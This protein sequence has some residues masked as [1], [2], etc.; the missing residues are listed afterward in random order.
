MRRRLVD[1][2]R[3]LSGHQS[4]ALQLNEANLAIQALQLAT[5]QQLGEIRAQLQQDI[6]RLERTLNLIGRQT[7]PV[8]D[9]YRVLFIVH[10][11]PNWSHLEPIYQL[12]RDAEDFD[13][14]VVSVDYNYVGGP[15]TDEAEVH[16]YLESRGIPHL[17]WGS[18]DNDNTRY[19][20]RY[21][22]P[23]LIFR[24][25]QWEG[26]VDPAL[27][28]SQSGFFRICNLPYAL[29]LVA[30]IEETIN[31]ELHHA[32]WRVFVPSELHVRHFRQHSRT[33]GRNVYAVGHPG[34]DSI[35][36]AKSSTGR[37][38]FPKNAG[39][40]RI[41]WAPRHCGKAEFRHHPLDLARHVEVRRGKSGD[42]DR[43]A[44][45]SHHVR[46]SRAL[47]VNDSSRH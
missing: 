25:S 12:M 3:R 19:L 40:G 5:E 17:R 1:F 45:A 33:G 2:Y 27:R 44:P 31:Q 4:L 41:L 37:W 16:E 29:D 43:D 9:Q 23:D 20:L 32:A 22:A 36:L 38:P 11:M 35:W 39:R 8:S 47:Q 15:P 14:I 7:A 42:R 28:T 46:D 6:A 24:Q 34:L 30:D 26:S 13:P 21:L 18:M 10:F